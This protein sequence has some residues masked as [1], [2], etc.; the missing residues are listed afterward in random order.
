MGG[1]EIALECISQEYLLF[2][3]DDFQNGG[4]RHDGCTL[5]VVLALCILV[6]HYGNNLDVRNEGGR[7]GLR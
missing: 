5:E 4:C 3:V 1:M 2:I 7:N 6:G